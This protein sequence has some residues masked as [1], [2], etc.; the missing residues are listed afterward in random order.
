M[1]QGIHSRLM[2]AVAVALVLTGVGAGADTVRAQAQG[3]Q[4]EGVRVHGR[5]T[6]EVRNANGTVAERREFENALTPEGVLTL[7]TLMTAQTQPGFWA[8]GLSDSLTSYGNSPCAVGACVLVPANSSTDPAFFR[9]LAV[10]I[11][12]FGATVQGVPSGALVLDGS[13]TATRNGAIA[14]VFTEW[15]VCFT[16]T[17]CPAQ[18]T[19]GGSPLSGVVSTAQ[20]PVTR[21]TTTSISSLAVQAGQIVQVTVA[22]SFS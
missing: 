14:G 13:F 20:P 10:G 18:L 6:I 5:W 7:A 21:F 11:S 4:V 19:S 15:Q 22:L 16:G 12:G 17:S 9:T 3:P 8:V 1:R 2:R